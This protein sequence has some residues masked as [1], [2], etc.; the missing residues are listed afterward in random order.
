MPP[1]VHPHY[2]SFFEMPSYKL[3]TIMGLSAWCK[4][5]PRPEFSTSLKVQLKRISTFWQIRAPWSFMLAH[6]F[7]YLLILS[8]IL[9]K[10]VEKSK[11]G[12]MIQFLRHAIVY[13]VNVTRWYL[14][15]FITETLA[16]WLDIRIVYSNFGL[17]VCFRRKNMNY[18]SVRSY[19]TVLDL[20]I[21]LPYYHSGEN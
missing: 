9:V 20:T 21:D 2:H 19:V 4:M 3:P 18:Y 6:I 15:L 7:F 10:N 12:N 8:Q 11:H 1:L 13:M 5:N 16:G 17:H 14:L